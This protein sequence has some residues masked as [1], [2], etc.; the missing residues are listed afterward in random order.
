MYVTFLQFLH[1]SFESLYCSSTNP[2]VA[3]WYGTDITCSTPFWRKKFLNSQLI[4]VG[5]LSDTTLSGK[6][7]WAKIVLRRWMAV[8]AIIVGIGWSSNHLECA[9]IT[10]KNIWPLKGPVKSMWRCDHD[11]LGH[12]Q[13]ISGANC[14]LGHKFWHSWQPLTFCSMSWSNTDHQ[15][16][17]H[18][19]LFIWVSPGWA[20][21]SSLSMSPWPALGITTWFPQRMQPSCTDNSSLLVANGLS[22]ISCTESGQPLCTNCR[23]REQRWSEF[24]HTLIRSAVIGVVFNSSINRIISGGRDVTSSDS[25]SGS[26]LIASAFPWAAVDL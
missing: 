18:A 3:G 4:K 13:G 21:C 17:I 8:C 1:P 12:F 6:P 24:V 7:N 10:T 26:L 9:S 16:N 23:T 19:S 2:L 5:P 15:T 25:W 14:G 11:W 20:S 22:C